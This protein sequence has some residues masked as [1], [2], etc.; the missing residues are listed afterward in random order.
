MYKLLILL[1]L[2][3]L[4]V[5]CGSPK[6]ETPVKPTA[7]IEATIKT[8]EPVTVVS[9]AKKGSY[10]EVGKIIGELMAWIKT[11]KV[12]MIGMPF[13]VYYDDPTKVSPES[14][15]YEVCVPVTPETKGDKQV[16]VKNLLAMEVAS[17]IFIGP[18]EKVGSA[19]GKLVTWIGEKGYEIVGPAREFYIN[20]PASVPVES[21]KTEVQFPVTKKTHK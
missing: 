16:E 12:N 6:K 17:T 20:D 8:V 11:K 5:G 7:I 14:T 10:Q 18:Y 19:Y 13:G 4:I 15:R 21:L 3:A 1:L 2:V 9:I